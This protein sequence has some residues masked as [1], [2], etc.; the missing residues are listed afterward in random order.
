MVAG[1]GRLIYL[2]QLTPSEEVAFL[3]DPRKDVRCSLDPSVRSVTSQ[4]PAYPDR[5]LAAVSLYKSFVAA[6]NAVQ[7][8]ALR[9]LVFTVTYADGGRE[10]WLIV[11]PDSLSVPLKEEPLPGSLTVGSGHPEPGPT[12]GDS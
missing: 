6:L 12:C 1:G 5:W 2:E 9:D 7:R 11:L 10:S 3:H 4:H 8:R